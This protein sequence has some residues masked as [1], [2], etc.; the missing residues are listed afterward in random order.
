MDQEFVGLV[1]GMSGLIGAVVG[2]LATAYGA[3]IGA[4][5]TIEA[6]HIQAERQSTDQ[7]RRWI[8]DQRSQVCSDVLASHASF[9]TTAINW[10]ATLRGG[11][12][13]AEEEYLRFQGQFVELVEVSARAD[14]WGPQYL[15][16]NSRALLKAA[17]AEFSALV[18]WSAATREGRASDITAVTQQYGA[19]R[20]AIQAARS[21]FIETA[22]RALQISNDSP[23]T[24]R[25]TLQG[26]ANR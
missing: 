1:A 17:G 7:Q 16:D 24:A 3:R 18:E 11:N 25:E 9:R 26:P 22:G 20:D 10:V 13:L 21:A 23:M 14:L 8:L 6:T 4:Q 12:P 19:A 5:K 2:G 15:V